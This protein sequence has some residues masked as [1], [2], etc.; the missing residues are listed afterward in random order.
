MHAFGRTVYISD[1]RT[2]NTPTV[3]KPPTF[4]EAARRA[5]II[6]AATQTIAEYGF[7]NA[8]LALIAKRAGISKSVIGYYF[9]TKDELVRAV[10]DSFYLAGHLQMME[11]LGKATSATEL[12]T[13]YIREN[14]AYI[15]EH[16]AETRAMG[17][18]VANFRQAD[19][20]PVF[21]IEDTEPLIEGTAKLFE[22]GQATGEF[23]RFDTRIMAVTLRAAVDAF[24][25]Q[26]GAYPDL[27][28]EQY[29][30]EMTE[31]FVQAAR[32]TS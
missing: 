11:K 23:R 19:G 28:I 3:R 2:G 17:D 16:R 4:I 13:L 24:S 6:D 32:T 21:K 18:I 29:T 26:L 22:W 1:V 20:Q 31:L 27:D 8:S 9:A 7:V 15:A 12:L 10:V 14:L 25:H 30:R 5:Q